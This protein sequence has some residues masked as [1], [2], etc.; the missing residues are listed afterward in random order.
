VFEGEAITNLTVGFSAMLNNTLRLGDDVTTFTLGRYCPFIPGWL[1][2]TAV[3][4]EHPP[5]VAEGFVVHSL[6]RPLRIVIAVQLV[7][8]DLAHALGQGAFVNIT[9]PASA[10]ASVVALTPSTTTVQRVDVGGHTTVLT[11]AVKFDKNCISVS[12]PVMNDPASVAGSWDLEAV[13]PFFV[14]VQRRNSPAAAPIKTDE[15]R[16]SRHKN[17]EQVLFANVNTDGREITASG[18]I[19]DAALA[20]GGYPV[21]TSLMTM[22][23][24]AQCIDPVASPGAPI[25][26]VRI[27]TVAQLGGEDSET[28]VAVAQCRYHVQKIPEQIFVMDL[29]SRT[30]TNNGKNWGPLR[31]NITHAHYRVP[32][33]WANATDGR[34]ADPNL[35]WDTERA[36]ML[37][38]YHVAMRA[39]GQG[40]PGSTHTFMVSS[41]DAVTWST[42]MLVNTY[43]AP[44]PGKGAAQLS[45]GLHKGR[46]LVASYGSGV[47]VWYS[48]DL[49]TWERSKML[50]IRG[51]W[52]ALNQSFWCS[53]FCE[54]Q[55]VEL[56]NGTVRLEM[57][58]CANGPGWPNSRGYSLSTDGGKNF[59][60]L[61]PSATLGDGGGSGCQGSIIRVGNVLYLSNANSFHTRSQLTV[62]RSTDDGGKKRPWNPYG[63][64]ASSTHPANFGASQGTGKASR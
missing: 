45:M 19:L 11:T 39:L 54:P 26:W 34:A 50:E 28:I 14:I 6:G 64:L 49:V 51:S 27:P 32:G 24:D 58:H 33:A 23:Y 4:P 15:T 43:G 25:N 31:A 44:G 7:A 29:C 46:V 21:R 5:S 22:C 57:R 17:S 40:V 47:G 53:N 2:H 12:V 10:L 60:L 30:S 48:D 36:Q 59:G 35:L 1:N 62:H 18:P 37:L 41:K 38:F 52:W 20:P 61:Q 13:A 56:T 8:F 55:L 16:L 3:C 63:Q 9:V 42:P